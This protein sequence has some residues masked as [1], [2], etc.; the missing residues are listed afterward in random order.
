MLD[1]DSNLRRFE[2]KHVIAHDHVGMLISV[3][4]RLV[5]WYFNNMHRSR[6]ISILLGWQ[7]MVDLRSTRA[8]Q[9]YPH[10]RQLDSF[11]CRMAHQDRVHNT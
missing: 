3:L 8:R 2:Q 1:V 6:Q 10:P 9:T 4:N 5:V 11:S 7:V